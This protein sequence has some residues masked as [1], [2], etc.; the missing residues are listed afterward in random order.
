MLQDEEDGLESNDSRAHVTAS[1]PQHSQQPYYVEPAIDNMYNEK[2]PTFIG[3]VSIHRYARY[4]DH[5]VIVSKK[6]KGVIIL[7]I[8]R[9]ASDLSPKVEPNLCA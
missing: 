8:N 4:V 5:L 6:K 7:G 2:K 3:V 1:V 9:G